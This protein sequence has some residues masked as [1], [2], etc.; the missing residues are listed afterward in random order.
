MKSFKIHYELKRDPE[1]GEQII[2][3]K[4]LTEALK[5]FNEMVKDDLALEAKCYTPDYYE[6]KV[7]NISELDDK[8]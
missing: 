7:T 5:V 1:H 3:A 2:K 4:S 8:S 6:I